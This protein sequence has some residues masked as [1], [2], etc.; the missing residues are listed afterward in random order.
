[1]GAQKGCPKYLKNTNKLILIRKI[2]IIKKQI[3][4]ILIT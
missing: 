3:I 4:N 1:M 2:K